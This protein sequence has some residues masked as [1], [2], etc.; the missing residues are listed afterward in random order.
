MN[1]PKRVEKRM[2]PPLSAPRLAAALKR[3]P[4]FLYILLEELKDFKVLGPWENTDS[5]GWIRWA[6]EGNAV[7]YVYPGGEN[8]LPSVAHQRYGPLQGTPEEARGW[9]DDKL[10]AEGYILL[11]QGTTTRSR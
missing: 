4:A 7:G 5:K 11:E 2:P 8:W 3:H 9:V 10:R 6:P 1:P